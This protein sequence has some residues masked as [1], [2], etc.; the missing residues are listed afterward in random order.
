MLGIAMDITCERGLPNNRLE[1]DHRGVYT[2]MIISGIDVA[3]QLKAFLFQLLQLR[4]RSAVKIEIKTF[5]R[6]FQVQR[7][8]VRDAGWTGVEFILIY[9]FYAVHHECRSR[10]R[11]MIWITEKCQMIRNFLR[12]HF[13]GFTITEIPFID[14]S[15]LT[16]H[17]AC[18]IFCDYVSIFFSRL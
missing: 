5:L 7:R 14:L 9:L 12:F 2:R 3:R 8:S 1:L 16:S 10:C 11:R 15:S 4:R 6:N 17:A 13:R 18:L